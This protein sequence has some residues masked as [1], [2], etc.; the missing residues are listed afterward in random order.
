MRPPENKTPGRGR[1]AGANG[2]RTANSDHSVAQGVPDAQATRRRLPAYGR[3]VAALRA[4]GFAPTVALLVADG[5]TPYTVAD[6]HRPWVLIVP[7]SEPPEAFDF[8]SVAGLFVYVVGFDS[9][10]VD[11]I[12]AQVEHYAPRAVYSWRGDVDVFTFYATEAA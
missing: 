12:V 9:A 8:R 10:R 4:G 5:W 1:G 6:E 11:A 3:Q 7:E 2:D